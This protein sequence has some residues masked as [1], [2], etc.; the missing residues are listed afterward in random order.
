M[1]SLDTAWN[2]RLASRQRVGSHASNRASML[3]DPCE[4]RLVLWRTAGEQASP[5]STETAGVFDMGHMVESYVRRTLAE[6][7]YEIEESQRD[8]PRNAYGITG[9]VDGLMTVDG[10]RVVV[11]IK[12]INGADWD[13]IN[14]EDDLKHNRKVWLRRWYSQMQVYLVLSDL[15]KGLVILYSKSTGL[16]K[17]VSVELNF[18]EAERLLEKAER[19]NKAVESGEMPAFIQDAGECRR[20]PFM[21]SACTPPLDYGPGAQ[22]ITDEELIALAEER[23]RHAE[24]AAAYEDADTRLKSALRGVENGVMGDYVIR[25]RWSPMTR[26]NVPKEVKAEYKVVEERGAFRLTIERVKA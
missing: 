2:E 22:V 4:R 1:K 13:R 21:G 25:G 14:S 19:V 8:F 18:S 11:E 5:I 12:S 10:E 15:K 26:Y 17:V 7:G 16:L 24:A 9:H 3:G 6:L 20:C 23:E